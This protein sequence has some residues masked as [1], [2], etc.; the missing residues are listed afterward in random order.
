M[1]EQAAR[2]ANDIGLHELTIT[3]VGRDLGIAPPGVY[4]H[5][6]DLDDLVAAIGEQAARE[7]AASIAS[8]CA[9]L[10]GRDAL[11]TLAYTLRSWA[12]AHSGQ[13]RALQIAPE[14]N[15]EPG[16]AASEELLVVIAATLRSYNL[17]GDD[18]TDA[19][20][21]IRSTLHGFIVLELDGGFKQP[22]DLD[23]TF[24]RIVASLDDVLTRWNHG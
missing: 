20:R 14:A 5:V 17:S 7:V 9:G 13:Y 10:S 4:R 19:I 22:R 21:F 15:N 6:V 24:D 16:Q 8:E 11:Q 2:L 1:I 12:H 18:R 23:C 3:K